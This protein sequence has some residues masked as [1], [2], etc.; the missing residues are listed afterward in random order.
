VLLV[1]FGDERK[2]GDGFH[3]V[4]MEDVLINEAAFQVAGPRWRLC[5]MVLEEGRVGVWH[6]LLGRGGCSVPVGLAR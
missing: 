1:V 5:S 4:D 2:A 6:G 3:E